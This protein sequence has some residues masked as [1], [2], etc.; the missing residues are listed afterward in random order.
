MRLLR[1]VA[2][3]EGYPPLKQVLSDPRISIALED[4]RLALRRGAERYDA[5]EMD[6]LEPNWAFSGYIY[7]IEF[8][9]LCATRLAPGGIVCMWSPT[10]RVKRSFL[11]S[12]PYCVAFR[13]GTVLVGSN[14]PIPVD[15][16]AWLARLA[17]PRIQAY[18]GTETARKVGDI[19]GGGDHAQPDPLPGEV[20]TDLFPRDEF[21]F[22]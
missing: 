4:G 1:G 14:E 10:P 12:F 21:M 16:Q 5:I 20:N 11:A 17:D 7:S 18:L 6:A 9:R 13:W 22:G 19:L 15:P 3:R 2:A 8:M